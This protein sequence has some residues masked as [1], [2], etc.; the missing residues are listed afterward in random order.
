VGERK[1]MNH[2]VVKCL[3]RFS[4]RLAALLN[5]TPSA[6]A[7]LSNFCRRCLSQI[8]SCGRVIVFSFDVFGHTLAYPRQLEFPQVFAFRRIAMQLLPYAL[9]IQEMIDLGRF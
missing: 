3:L 8:S 1:I 5:L 6:T 4:L 9:T 7:A 2:F